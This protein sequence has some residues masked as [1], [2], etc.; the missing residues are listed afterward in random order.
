METI[1]NTMY[2]G[3]TSIDELMHEFGSPLYIYEEDV[4]RTHFRKLRDSFSGVSLKIHYAMKANYNPSLLKILLEEGAC[5]D[6]VSPFE[7]M[8]ARKVGF[9][10]E[11]ILF[12]GNNVPLEEI[13]FCIENE[14]PVNIESVSLLKQFGETYPGSEVSIRINPGIGSGHH[15]HCITGGP[16]SKFG[17]YHDQLDQAHK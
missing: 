15:A 4:I 12:T 5:I 8:L 9:A 13:T 3:G 17:I 2:L 1:N 11:N 6:A 14:I 10:P 7:V 16:K